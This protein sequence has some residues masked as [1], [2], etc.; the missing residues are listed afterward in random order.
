MYRDVQKGE[1]GP[2]AWTYLEPSPG[3]CCWARV[4]RVCAGQHLT[5]SSGGGATCASA[6]VHAL[7]H[8]GSQQVNLHQHPTTICRWLS[9]KTP[10]KEGGREGYIFRVDH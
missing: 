10:R 1:M 7:I 3:H 2:E 5:L 9:A 8:A 6:G 4:E